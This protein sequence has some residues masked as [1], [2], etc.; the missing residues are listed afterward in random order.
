MARPYITGRGDKNIST[1]YSHHENHGGNMYS[2]SFN[3]TLASSATM[4]VLIVT[5]DS[6]DLAHMVIETR[7]SG[8]ANMSVFEGTT[9]SGAGTA[10][11]ETNHNRS[12]SNTAGT[13]ITH[14][15]TITGDGTELKG[16]ARHFG[17][18]QQTGGEVRAQDE[19]VLA[20]DTI[21]LIRVTSE[22]AANDITT[23]LTWYESDDSY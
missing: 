21:Y 3:A 23:M 18:G 20:S 6:D 7:S 13:V 15:P 5:A 19:I 10:L 14:T 4:E 2:S 16:L 9:V 17:S 8:E 1:D 22:A 11:E 12:S